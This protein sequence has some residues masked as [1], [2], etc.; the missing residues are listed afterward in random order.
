[1]FNLKRILHNLNISILC[2]YTFFSLVTLIIYIKINKLVHCASIFAE[3]FYTPYRTFLNIANDGILQIFTS[4]DH[5]WFILSMFDVL[6]ARYLPKFL[7]IHPQICEKN[8]VSIFIFSLVLLFIAN[9]SDNLSKYSKNRFLSFLGILLIFP[10]IIY[11]VQKADF[12]FGFCNPIW[13]YAYFLLPLFPFLLL[14]EF[15]LFYITGEKPCKKNMYIIAFLIFCTAIS[16]EFFRIVFIIALLTCYIFQHF[17]LKNVN[18]KKFWTIYSIFTALNMLL[19]FSQPFVMIAKDR[20]RL[21]YYK[22]YDYVANLFVQFLRG[23]K[24]FLLLPNFWLFVI[25]FVSWIIIFLFVK[26]NIKKTKFYIYSFSLFFA[27]FIFCL[28]MF[29]VN[30]YGGMFIILSH[31]GLRF[32]FSSLLLSL[33]C[34]SIGFAIKYSDSKKV[35]NTLKL[36]ILTPLLLFFNN[37]LFDFDEISDTSNKHREDAYILEKVYLLNRSKNDGIYMYARND[38][39]CSFDGAEV[40]L[41]HLYGWKEV[42]YGSNEVK[43]VCIAGIDDWTTCRDNLIKKAAELG[44][45]FTE[46]EI[47]NHNFSDLYKLK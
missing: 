10:V 47:K 6:S 25:L 7:N 2:E 21:E 23:I 18:H 19:F 37:N 46:E 3:G 40:Y 5:S 28:M 22:N 33:I 14:K 12:L 27:A 9:F 17:L 24:E 4:S 35:K 41:S 15:E 30:N 43:E 16:H 13:I 26:D 1:M 32:L 31:S 34:S 29:F 11:C 36:L 20:G 44:S 42:D 45:P 8:I 39:W 38:D